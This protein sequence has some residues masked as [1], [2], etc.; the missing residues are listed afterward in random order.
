MDIEQFI[1]DM[2]W[3][4]NL[5]IEKLIEQIHAVV[6]RYEILAL[7]YQ[8]IEN[9]YLKA[10]DS[11]ARASLFNGYSI[12]LGYGFSKD[13]E[14]IELIEYHP[15]PTEMKY[16]VFSNSIEILQTDSYPEASEK[17]REMLDERF[18]IMRDL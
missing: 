16:F 14:C 7:A 11:M 4:D 6:K 15:T 18:G 12:P 9:K 3:E 5:D 17:F 8:D 13:S 10:L 2:D 1:K